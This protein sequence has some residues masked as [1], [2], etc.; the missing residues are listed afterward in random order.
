MAPEQFEGQSTRASDIYSIG[1]TLYEL[2]TLRPAFEERDAGQLMRR[3]TRHGPVRPRTIDPAIPRDLETIILKAG[4]FDQNHRYQSA[5]EL[6]DDLQ[7]YLNGEPIAAR[8]VSPVARFWRWSQR[9]PALATLGGLS[10]AL[11]LLVAIVASIGYVRVDDARQEAIRLAAHQRRD[12]H[13][14]RLANRQVLSETQRAKQEFQRAEDNLR[15]AMKAFEEIIDRVSHRSLPESLDLEMEADTPIA[16]PP[17]ITRA[18]A[19]LL[20]S[21]LQFYIEF[22]DRNGANEALQLQTAKAYHRIGDIRLQLGQ[23]DLAAKAHDEALQLYD[24]CA[25]QEEPD[26]VLVLAAAEVLRHHG[27]A[28]AKSSRIF[29]AIRILTEARDRLLQQPEEISRSRECRF[30]LAQT[31][32]LLGSWWPQG[33]STLDMILPPNLSRR[34]GLDS[35]AVPLRLGVPYWMEQNCGAALDILDNLIAEDP[36]NADY[37]LALAQCHRNFLSVAW[38][39]QKI[40][41]AADR[42]EECVRILEQLTSDFP[43]NP[44]YAFELADVLSTNTPTVRET[45]VGTMA[46][47][48]LQRAVAIARRLHQS[49]PNQPEYQV[50]YA[51]SQH[52]LGLALGR[53]GGGTEATEHLSE[54]MNSFENLFERFPTVPVYIA[55]FGRVA[56][57][58]GVFQRNAGQYQASRE[59]LENA[60]LH[61]IAIT[62]EDV[63]MRLVRR[64]L[65]TLYANLHRTLDFLATHEVHSP[66]AN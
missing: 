63:D 51:N 58:L 66:Q 46:V 34:R 25:S 56:N 38:R 27:I 26:L 17:L 48:R 18:D 44:R 4:A 10:F 57:D 31:Y 19:E 59:T 15:L 43:D 53:S 32:N 16:N 12:A 40:P 65:A 54:A 50:L 42:L 9:N 30:A 21:L 28:L 11:L 55:S 3:V 33:D 1:I 22:A 29:D 47:S 64:S 60:I 24:R 5:G 20:Q 37:R 8:R 62:Y 7:R 35:R 49:W 36:S 14:L 45:E 13:A 39:G 52:R 23:F 2:A 6:G 41:Q 61:F